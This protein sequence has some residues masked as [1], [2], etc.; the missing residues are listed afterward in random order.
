MIIKE[1]DFFFDICKTTF[2]V[3]TQRRHIRQYNN[4]IIGFQYSKKDIQNTFKQCN[5][6]EK[7]SFCNSFHLNMTEDMHKLSTEWNSLLQNACESQAKSNQVLNEPTQKCK[8]EK[9]LSLLNILFFENLN[10]SLYEYLITHVI[11]I[12]VCKNTIQWNL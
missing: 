2:V 3:G 12:L 11:L 9:V 4:L 6:Y 5:N 8:V 7:L 1:N 10:I